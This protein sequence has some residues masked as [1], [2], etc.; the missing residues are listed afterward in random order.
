[1]FFV[2]GWRWLGEAVEVP[3]V[4]QCVLATPGAAR[5]GAE[6]KLLERAK[7]RAPE[8]FEA[9][10]EQIAK[11]AGTVS[12]AGVVALVKW[13]AFDLSR[14]SEEVS[15]PGPALIAVLDGV[16]DPG[17]AGT[18]VRTSDWFGVRGVLLG[19]GSAEPPNPKVARATM[20]SL[21]HLPIAV[22]DDVSGSLSALR[23]SG[24]VTVGAVLGGDDSM[25]FEWPERVAL[26]VGNE[27]NGV[28]AAV[29]A[30]LDHRVSIRSFGRAESLNAAAAFAV[31]ASDWRRRYHTP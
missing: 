27:A 17:N 13:S 16:G 1:M 25:H 2:D 19:S 23:E 29:A 5:T 22:A 15:A 4:L 6:K 14:F 10:P 18:I 26:V 30:R 12:P 8:F 21:F 11:L 28:S 31:L 20:G 9:R 3:G 24:F 7:S